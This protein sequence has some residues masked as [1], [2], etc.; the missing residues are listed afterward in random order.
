GKMLLVLNAGPRWYGPYAQTKEANAKGLIPLYDDSAKSIKDSPVTDCNRVTILPR[1]PRPQYLV[2]A[3]IPLSASA[4]VGRTV[5]LGNGQNVYASLTNL[6]V[7]SPDWAYS[8]RNSVGSSSE[9]TNIYRFAYTTG[10]TE[11][12]SQGSVKGHI[13]NQFSMDE[14]GDTFRIATTVSAQWIGGDVRI[15]EGTTS[16]QMTKSTNNLYVLNKNLDNLGSVTDIAPGESIYSVRF[17]G[18]RAYMVTFKQVDP[19]FV[20]D[21]TDA[22]NPKI[23]GKLKIPGYSNY[24]HPV[25]ENHVLGFG[26]EVDESIDKDKVHSDDAVYY[27]AILGMK[28]ALF[29]VTDVANPK[30]LHKEVIGA[31]GTDSPL[32][33]DHKALL[34]DKERGLLAFPVTVYEKKSSPKVNEW[35]ADTMPVF[36]G[37]YV[38]DFNVNSGFSLKGTITHHTPDDFMKSGDYWYDQTGLDIDRIVRINNTLFSFSEAKL[39]ANALTG[40]RSEGQVDLA[41]ELT[42]EYPPMRMMIE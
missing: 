31:R 34:F 7:A 11:F 10:G 12:S 26:K 2:I 39:S 9:K 36:Q 25:D 42:D 33:S 16:P 28:I 23:L 32:L 41:T 27:T 35:D 22:R 18:N 14:N 24:L 8:W 19:L 6:Y 30:E 4:E 21:L 17:T 38:Y 29:D 3:S 40:L 20:I 15:M 37:A 1:V 5:I 13:L